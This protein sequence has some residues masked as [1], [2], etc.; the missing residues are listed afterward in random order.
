MK[1][2]PKGLLKGFLDKGYKEGKAQLGSEDKQASSCGEEELFGKEILCEDGSP[3]EWV[4]ESESESES[5]QR[6]VMRAKH[7]KKTGK[8]KK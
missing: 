3:E 4:S 5:E 8:G 7:A 6:A 2:K 1:D